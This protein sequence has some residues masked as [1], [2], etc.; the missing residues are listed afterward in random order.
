[1]PRK[2]KQQQP[3]GGNTGIPG[4]SKPQP[5][6]GSSPPVELEWKSLATK[7]SAASNSDPPI[8]V[9]TSNSSKAKVYG[10]EPYLVGNTAPIDGTNTY[11]YVFSKFYR[12][13]QKG[14]A[15]TTDQY[16]AG[17]LLFDS[18]QQL[19][20]VFNG[21]SANSAGP[22]LLSYTFDTKYNTGIRFPPGDSRRAHT[23]APAYKKNDVLVGVARVKG[24]QSKET[25]ANGKLLYAIMKDYIRANLDLGQRP[26]KFDDYYQM[27]YGLDRENSRDE[28]SSRYWKFKTTLGIIGETKR[29]T[30]RL[31]KN[32]K[33]K[34]VMQVYNEQT[35]KW[36]SAHLTT[37]AQPALKVPEEYKDSFM[38]VLK[39]LILRI[40]DTESRRYYVTPW[41]RTNDSTMNHQNNSKQY[42]E[43][44]VDNIRR[45]VTTLKALVTTIPPSLPRD[46]FW[47]RA[48]QINTMLYTTVQSRTTVKK[49]ISTQ[50][51]DRNRRED[52]TYFLDMFRHPTGY[53]AMNSLS[54]FSQAHSLTQQFLLAM[55]YDVMF[56][57][58][59]IPRNYF[60]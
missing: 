30:V 1:M 24:C 57:N 21:L 38:A 11:Q 53:E 20:N 44:R 37:S 43:H 6:P 28:L 22:G 14:A 52:Y 2:S 39:C 12:A 58:R 47:L 9:D 31:Y 60:K 42:W 48:G 56:L 35:R 25:T 7:F 17:K 27:T 8:L 18:I 41:Y 23:G 4:G 26:G 34:I 29:K 49:D 54:L 19:Y 36:G 5:P 3:P 33:G 13:L 46:E 10:I 59:S 32:D 16:S 45:M 55:G 51:N 40:L 50:R 15:N